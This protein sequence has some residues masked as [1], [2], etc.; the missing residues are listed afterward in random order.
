MPPLMKSAHSPI[1][2]MANFVRI[3]DCLVFECAYW[4]DGPTCPIL[5]GL[6]NEVAKKI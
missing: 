3:M 6:I 4:Y 2:D 1:C 5:M